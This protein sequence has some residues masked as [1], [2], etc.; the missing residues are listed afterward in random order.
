MTCSLALQPQRPSM[1]SSSACAW[2]LARSGPGRVGRGCLGDLLGNEKEPTPGCPQIREKFLPVG[3][4]GKSPLNTVLAETLKFE[5][6][7]AIAQATH[8]KKYLTFAGV[9]LSGLAQKRKGNPPFWRVPCGWTKSN[10]HHFEDIRTI[11]CWYLQE[12][13][14]IRWFLRWCR[15]LSVHS[16]L[17]HYSCSVTRQVANV[18]PFCSLTL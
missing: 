18:K 5:P 2:T 3:L 12:G 9:A 6:W 8:N 13:M 14:I 17:R 1:R 7:H 15:I 16:I 4:N 11:V 10:S